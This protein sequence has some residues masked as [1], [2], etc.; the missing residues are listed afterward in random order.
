MITLVLSRKV[1][2][3]LL[4]ERSKSTSLKACATN[5]WV[6]AA[7]VAA[8]I[9]SLTSG[10]QHSQPLGGRED[11]RM[12]E[13]FTV[14]FTGIG[15]ICCVA[16]IL[17]ASIAYLY[18]DTL[19]DDACES[20]LSTFPYLV[21]RPIIY[22]AFGI[23]YFMLGS[24]TFLYINYGPAVTFMVSIAYLIISIYVLLEWYWMSSF[25]NEIDSSR[26]ADEGG[27]SG[28]DDDEKTELTTVDG[29]HFQ[30]SFKRVSSV[31]SATDGLQGSKAVEMRTAQ[32]ILPPPHR[33][34]E[35]K[36]DEGYTVG[37]AAEDGATLP[38]QH[39]SD[40]EEEGSPIRTSIANPLKILSNE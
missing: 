33:A 38:G 4:E 11:I 8:L 1:S 28:A 36:G 35:I 31:T 39:K 29:L 37:A 6:N 3:D 32:T 14:C 18:T 13:V 30:K 26:L 20:F 9:F 22:M 10:L 2:K 16:S 34:T 17:L 5:N 23:L 19:S 21:G 24:I 27:A 15:S 25:K 40:G 12:S 7:I